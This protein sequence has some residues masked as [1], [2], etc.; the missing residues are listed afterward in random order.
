MGKEHK[1]D[2]KVITSLSL[3]IDAIKEVF[4]KIDLADV[5][6][7][8]VGY[9]FGDD[10]PLKRV[11]GTIKVNHPY[12]GRIELSMIFPVIEDKNI[13]TI[14]V[15]PTKIEAIFTDFPYLSVELSPT[16]EIVR[17]ISEILK[18]KLNVS[19]LKELEKEATRLKAALKTNEV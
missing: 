18:E 5:E 15:F 2:M 9:V 13:R 14:G 10:I 1:K 4:E 16:L 8:T 12:G 6:E 11:H 19:T 17:F 3:D 7:V